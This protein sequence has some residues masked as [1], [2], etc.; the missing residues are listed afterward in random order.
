[1]S[2]AELTSLTTSTQPQQHS[3]L[4]FPTTAAIPT[5]SAGITF[6]TTVP[7]QTGSASKDIFD[8]M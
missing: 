3:G 7:A 6:N 4:M 8:M 5:Q 2:I 1:M